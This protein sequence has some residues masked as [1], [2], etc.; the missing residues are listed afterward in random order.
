MQIYS[1]APIPKPPTYVSHNL[2]TFTNELGQSIDGCSERRRTAWGRGR[3]TKRKRHAR[4]SDANHMLTFSNFPRQPH[5]HQKRVHPE[6]NWDQA[7]AFLM[8]N[9]WLRHL[10]TFACVC[11]LSVFVTDPGN[12]AHLITSSPQQMVLN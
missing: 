4:H 1:H 6:E 2:K 5:P 12:S 9:V 11:Q 8:Q 7:K 10:P 3:N